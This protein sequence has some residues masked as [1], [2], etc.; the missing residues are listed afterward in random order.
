MDAPYH[1][2]VASEEVRTAG[3]SDIINIRIKELYSNKCQNTIIN[4]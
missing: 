3:R 4:V 2:R 1:G